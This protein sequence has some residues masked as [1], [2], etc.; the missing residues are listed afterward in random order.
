MLPPASRCE[1]I[2]DVVEVKMK[3]S[4]CDA[5]ASSSKLSVPCT[6]DRNEVRRSM[7]LDMRLVQGSGMNNRL[8]LEVANR[9]V[10]QF[11]VDDS[12]DDLRIA[13]RYEVQANDL[14]PLSGQSRYQGLPQPGRR[15]SNQNAQVSYSLAGLTE[16]S[17]P[18]VP[19]R[20]ALRRCIGLQNRPS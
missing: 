14:M 20:A 12:A 11:S 9:P 17:W 1:I 7:R 16:Y 6:F 15:A 18:T 8:C 19:C 10:H 5:T 13:R 2:N 3:H 4:T